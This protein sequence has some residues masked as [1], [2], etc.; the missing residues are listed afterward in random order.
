MGN[1]EN[2]VIPHNQLAPN[3]FALHGGR[4]ALFLN[5]L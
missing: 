5:I 3:T 1:D 4:F 2:L